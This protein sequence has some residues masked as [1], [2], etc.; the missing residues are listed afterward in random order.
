MAATIISDCLIAERRLK[1]S[2]LCVGV[3]ELQVV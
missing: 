1:A 2:V 3:H